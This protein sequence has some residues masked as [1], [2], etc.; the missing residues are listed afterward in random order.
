[1][2]HQK[3]ENLLSLDRQGGAPDTLRLLLVV[4]RSGELGRFSDA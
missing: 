4:R 2:V 1:M 3:V